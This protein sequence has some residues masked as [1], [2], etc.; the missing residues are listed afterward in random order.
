TI[1]STPAPSTC[2]RIPA[3]SPPTH[4]TS[5]LT[6]HRE[7]EDGHRRQREGQGE[8]RRQRQVRVPVVQGRPAVPRRPR[9]PLPQS[10]QVR[11][12]RRRRRPRLPG[13]RSRVPRRRGTH[14]PP[15]LVLL[16]FPRFLCSRSHCFL[17]LSNSDPGA[18]WERGAGQQEEPDRAAPHPAGGAQRRGAEPSAGL[19]HHRR[20]RGAA[21]HPHHAAPQEGRQ[22]QGRHRLRFPG[23]LD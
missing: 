8:A 2:S 22:G 10:R 15:C 5:A 14:P 21:Q 12:A 11:A 16:P 18:R 6:H 23:V 3:I 7:P 1:P 4:S 19:G 20:R 9:R 17:F 13:R